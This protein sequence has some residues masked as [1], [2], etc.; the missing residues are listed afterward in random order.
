[1][2]TRASCD[3]EPT[4]SDDILKASLQSIH[5]EELK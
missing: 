5:Y 1:V 3:K 2:F 4:L